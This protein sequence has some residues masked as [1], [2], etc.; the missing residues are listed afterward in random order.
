MG[1]SHFKYAL[2]V[3]YRGA[4]FHHYYTRSVSEWQRKNARGDAYFGKSRRY[5]ELPTG[6]DDVLN[7]ELVSSVRERLRWLLERHGG[8][9]A[10]AA[11]ASRLQVLLLEGVPSVDEL[12]AM[13][14]RD[15][16]ELWTKEFRTRGENNQQAKR[17]PTQ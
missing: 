5:T 1:T 15:G 16:S 8:K 12:A 6:V 14:P 2:V 13:Q 7:T 11:W 4:W 9:P 10:V 3:C 17:W